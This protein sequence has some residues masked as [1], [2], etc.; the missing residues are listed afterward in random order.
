ML[1][2][3]RNPLRRSNPEDLD[4]N[5]HRRENPIESTEQWIIVLTNQAL[6][7]VLERLNAV[8]SGISSTKP[9]LS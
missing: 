8:N 6:C 1:V 3:Y 2:S 5:L 7:I 4:M 9:L